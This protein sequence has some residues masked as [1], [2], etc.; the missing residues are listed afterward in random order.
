MRCNQQTTIEKSGRVRV[1]KPFGG[2]KVRYLPEVET[3]GV[4]KDDIEL[5]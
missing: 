4:L 3:V 5:G 1:S 2:L